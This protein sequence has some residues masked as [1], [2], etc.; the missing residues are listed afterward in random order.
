MRPVSHRAH[1]P[2]VVPPHLTKLA[3]HAHHRT[4]NLL[5]AH[6][7]YSHVTPLRSRRFRMPRTT[8][9]FR[10][11]APM[12]IADNVADIRRARIML[13]STASPSAS[14]KTD[15]DENLFS[16][17]PSRNV[18]YAVRSDDPLAFGSCYWLRPNGADR[19]HY[20]V[21]FFSVFE[22]C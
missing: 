17:P 3:S 11:P 21:R 14:F 15:A 4:L 12:K 18:P 19:C 16:Y 8:S 1:T 20:L 13:C 22:H 5:V 9:F 6:A 10:F 2:V 7:P